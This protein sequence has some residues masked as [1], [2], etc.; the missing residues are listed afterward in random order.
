MEEKSPASCRREAGS[1]SGRSRG[2]LGAGSG[3]ASA[4]PAGDSGT[5]AALGHRQHLRCP[6]A[7]AGS[8]CPTAASRQVRSPSASRRGRN[9]LTCAWT[10]FRGNL[11]R[12]DVARPFAILQF[13]KIRA[14]VIFSLSYV[15]MRLTVKL[16]V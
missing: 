1:G 14:Q 2:H 10:K 6:R 9:A 13:A 3:R 16:P 15:S 7:G 11:K 12:V 5:A 8:P 4:A